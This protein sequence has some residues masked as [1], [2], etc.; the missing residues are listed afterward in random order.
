MAASC[1]GR[2]QPRTEQSRI[3]SSGLE[4]RYLVSQA[5]KHLS[6]PSTPYLTSFRW[7]EYKMDI[8]LP[9]PPPP[10]P[11]PMIFR[12]WKSRSADG[13]H[14]IPPEVVCSSAGSFLS[15]QVFSQE[16]LKFFSR[17]TRFQRKASNILA[18]P[19][20][21]HVWDIGKVGCHRN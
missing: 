8:V 21:G 19:A 14:I 13:R 5:L 6:Q 4:V 15:T 9:D 20:W 16:S 2:T 10:P 18:V 3:E 1:S 12:T 17:V 7:S 11:S